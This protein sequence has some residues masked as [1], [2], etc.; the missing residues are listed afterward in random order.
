MTRAANDSDGSH[1]IALARA[2][3]LSG[4]RPAQTEAEVTAVNQVRQSLAGSPLESNE[5]VALARRI[6]LSGF[7]S[8]VRSE[9][10]CETASQETPPAESPI[11]RVQRAPAPTASSAPGQRASAQSAGFVVLEFLGQEG[12]TALRQFESIHGPLCADINGTAGRLS[13][14]DAAR[15]RFLFRMPADGDSA[16]LLRNR[17]GA[18]LSGVATI[19]VQAGANLSEYAFVT[20]LG[21]TIGSSAIAPVP[22]LP[23]SVIRALGGRA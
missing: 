6:G 21:Q 2:V 9:P 7:A 8:D 16:N 12:L 5:A 20:Q 4:V 10:A 17:Q 11:G 3:G 1:V 22:H 14:G 18:F 13:S 15:P 23:N 19:S